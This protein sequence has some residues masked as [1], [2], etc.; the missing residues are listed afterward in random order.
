[1]WDHDS[2]LQTIKGLEQLAWKRLEVERRIAECEAMAESARR[3]LGDVMREFK[4]RQSEITDIVGDNASQSGKVGIGDAVTALL[5]ADPSRSFSVAEIG[6]LLHPAPRHGTLLQ[7]CARLVRQRR[8]RR[9]RKGVYRSM[10][11]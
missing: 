6:G 10:L 8:A 2:V 9:V 3:E 1:M 7:A 5:D 4:E 11:K